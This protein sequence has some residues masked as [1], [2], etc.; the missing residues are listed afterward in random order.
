MSRLLK[1]VG[2]PYMVPDLVSSRG[3]STMSS[4]VSF[5]PRNTKEGVAN[6][7]G[8]KIQGHR[9]IPVKIQDNYTRQIKQFYS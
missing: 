9:S 3:E 4:K 2:R 7:T 6:W 5:L 1:A 8:R